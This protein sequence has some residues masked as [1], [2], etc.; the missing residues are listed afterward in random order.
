MAVSTIQG[1]LSVQQKILKRRL[2]L[3]CSSQ[4]KV[5]AVFVLG[6]SQA[7]AQQLRDSP[8]ASTSLKSYSLMKAL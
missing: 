1:V 8:L 5:R 2:E 4:D 6:A 3:L 7:M